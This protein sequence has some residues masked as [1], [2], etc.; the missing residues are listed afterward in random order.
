M[1]KLI[2]TCILVVAPSHQKVLN[3]LWALNISKQLQ[4]SC[5]HEPGFR[6]L[7]ALYKLLRVIKV[8]LLFDPDLT[9]TVSSLVIK[10]VILE[11]LITFLFVPFKP[12]CILFFI[13]G[14]RVLWK[15]IGFKLRNW[16]Y[17]WVFLESWA[18]NFFYKLLLSLSLLLL[19]VFS[20]L[21]SGKLS[22]LL[23]LLEL[24]SLLILLDFLLFSCP[25]IL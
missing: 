3:S 1:V 5:S 25:F 20:L 21:L 19:L 24:L 8:D 7:N 15:I 13:F 23:L 16:L 12:F 22:F 17:S 9:E 4:D 11:Y 10:W 6:P 2:L 18:R 14:E